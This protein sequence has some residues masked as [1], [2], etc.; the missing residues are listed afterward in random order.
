MYNLNDI[1]DLLS[2]S[3]FRL[4]LETSG[5]YP[6][7]GKWNWIT[8]SPKKIQPPLSEIY[9]LASE[10]KIIIYNKHDFEWALEESHKVNPS[11]LLYVQPEWSKKDIMQPLIL[12]FLSKHKKWKLSLQ[13]HKY[14]N[15]K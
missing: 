14:L 12:D 3:G 7:T 5:A 10:L 9:H 6:I 13:M 2:K 4:H 8:L 15:I 1:S 11:C